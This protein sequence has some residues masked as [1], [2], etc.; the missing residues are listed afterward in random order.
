M[1]MRMMTT[2]MTMIVT[3]TMTTTMTTTT[4]TTTIVIIVQTFIQDIRHTYKF[5]HTVLNNF[6]GVT[7]KSRCYLTL[8]TARKEYY[9]NASILT[10]LIGIYIVSFL[11]Q[12]TSISCDCKIVFLIA[13][14]AT[15]RFTF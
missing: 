3:M 7:H 8:V 9:E 12:Y 1:I 11:R 15:R 10:S 2:T 13:V 4:T 6:S 5:V 14:R